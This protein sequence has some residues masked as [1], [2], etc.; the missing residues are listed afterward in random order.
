MKEKHGK[1]WK[2]SRRGRKPKRLNTRFET[3]RLAN[4][5]TLVEALTRCRKQLSMSR[6]K[7]SVTQEKRAK[8]LFELYPKLEQA[9]NLTGSLRAIFRNKKLTKETA[10]ERFEEW[11]EKVARCTLREIKSVRDTIKFYE[12]E[13]LNYFNGRKTNASAESLNLKIKCFRSQMKGVRDIPFFMYR[14]AT[15]L[16]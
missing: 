16:G 9:Y 1:K 6:E 5:E 7:W 12:D 4:A 8:I 10:K 13:I 2:K 3:P 15:V 11:Y 14:L